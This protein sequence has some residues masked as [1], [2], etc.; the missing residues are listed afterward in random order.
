MPIGQIPGFPDFDLKFQ[1]NLCV[2]TLKEEEWTNAINADNG[3]PLRALINERKCPSYTIKSI[4]IA[5]RCV[6]DFGLIQDQ[7]DNST[8]MTDANGNPIEN[9]EEGIVDVGDVLESIKSIVD[10][11]NLQQFAEK[12]LSDL[13][14]TWP[15]L[16]AGVGISKIKDTRSP[17]PLFTSYFR[18][19]HLL[20]LDLLDEVH[21]R[22][23]DLAFSRAHHCPPSSQF[24]LHL[25][26]IRRLEGGARCRRIHMERQPNDSGDLVFLSRSSEFSELS[27]PL[28]RI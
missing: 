20:L 5:G 15:M 6:P 2:P 4:G 10:I 14:K 16:L 12:F 24:C 21:C 26:E 13:V 3:D 7:T 25:D 1:R 27:S 18:S 22:G 9:G 23:D 11:L 19:C 17:F 28:L 8:S